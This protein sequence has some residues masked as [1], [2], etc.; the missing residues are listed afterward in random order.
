MYLLVPE[1]NKSGSRFVPHSVCRTSQSHGTE[2]A[3]TRSETWSRHIQTGRIHSLRLSAAYCAI[4]APQLPEQLRLRKRTCS[5]FL[6][7]PNAPLAGTL[8]WRMT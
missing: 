5:A 1:A 4:T 3:I 8:P 7:S 2:I 6:R